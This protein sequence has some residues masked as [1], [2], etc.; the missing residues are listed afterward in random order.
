MCKKFAIFSIPL[1]LLASCS[2]PKPY[3][4]VRII[5]E[6][7]WGNS[8]VDM[9]ETTPYINA[10]GN[11]LTLH[12]LEYFISD[13]IVGNVAMTSAKYGNIHYIRPDNDAF[14]TL[15]LTHQIPVGPYNNIAFTFGLDNTKN[16]SNL[17]PNSPEKDMFWPENMGGGY[18]FM[19]FDGKWKNPGEP[20]N[21]GFGLHLGTLKKTIERQNE[22]IDTLF[23]NHFRVS[24]P[25][26]FEV[27]ANETTTIYVFVDLKQWMESPYT[28][29]FNVMG[30]EIMSRE[31]AL[32]SLARNGRNVFK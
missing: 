25:K 10:A 17:F 28:W 8:A 21:Q 24:V 15:F 26:N 11:T 4:Y 18:H 1:L 27:N 7:R 2:N 22:K 12:N 30:G 29:D 5:F 20:T 32:D 16:K 14:A 13:L 3:G 19:K 6:H 9:D 31:Q 23:P